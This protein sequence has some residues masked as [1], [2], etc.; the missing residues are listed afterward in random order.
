MAS[1]RIEGSGRDRER[2]V[3]QM[4]ALATIM[5]GIVGTLVMLIN[6]LTMRHTVRREREMAK[7]HAMALARDSQ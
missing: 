5:I 1:A 2:G 3:P 4:N 6:Y 7:L